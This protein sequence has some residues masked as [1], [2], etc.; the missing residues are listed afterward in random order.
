VAGSLNRVIETKRLCLIQLDLE[1]LETSLVNK[2]NTV[3]L[4]DFGLSPYWFEEKS[5]ISTRISQIKH[6]PHLSSWL[7]RAIVRRSDN[8]MIGHFNAH[9][10]PGM[11][12][13]NSYCRDGLEIGYT[14]YKPYRR[15]GFASEALSGFIESMP[16][17]VSVV[18]SVEE[19][20]KPS[21]KMA[22][23]LKFEQVGQ[24]VDKGKVELVH[25]RRFV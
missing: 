9:G 13:L 5:L 25:H 23:K 6:Q 18:L 14:I 7:L 2:S 22:K 20:N 21:L 24:V 8:Q 12:H 11:V 4:V 17:P 19:S 16:K 15:M 3:A 1:F 10:K